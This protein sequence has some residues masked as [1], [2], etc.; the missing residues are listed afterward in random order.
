MLLEQKNKILLEHLANEKAQ[1]ANN[2]KNSHDIIFENYRIH[3]NS[4]KKFNSMGKNQ[5]N[6]TFH[7]QEREQARGNNSLILIYINYLLDYELKKT[8][9]NFNFNFN[10]NSS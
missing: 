1:Q 7:H 8:F 9:S 2:L 5:F 10:K 6:L 4:S 3:K